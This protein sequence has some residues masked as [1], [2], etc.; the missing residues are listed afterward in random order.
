[1]HR[2]GATPRVRRGPSGP[3][4][5]L[6]HHR[7]GGVHRR[8]HGTPSAITV[9]PASRPEHAFASSYRGAGRRLSRHQAL[10]QW[11]GRQLVDELRDRDI[12][13][14]IIIIIKNPS[15]R[16]VV[17]EAPGAYKDSTTVVEV[18]HLAD[19]SRKVAKL[20]PVICIKAEMGRTK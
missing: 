14:I 9:G 6:R 16:G 17:E 7:P 13:I 1:M 2:T 3:A 11:R 15:M 20:E 5:G 18:A 4:D 10:K 8:Q 12:I 19:L